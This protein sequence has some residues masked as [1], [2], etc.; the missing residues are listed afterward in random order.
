[1]FLNPLFTQ[2]G[3]IPLHAAAAAGNEEAAAVIV[4]WSDSALASVAWRLQFSALKKGVSS[5][6]GCRMKA[7]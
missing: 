4:G 7:S 2:D 6:I 3:R 1:M 5:G